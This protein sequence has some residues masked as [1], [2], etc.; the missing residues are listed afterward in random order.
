MKVNNHEVMTATDC[1]SCG[2]K[3]D[4][5]TGV[6]DQNAMPGAGDVSICA[7]CA[8]ILVFD[9]KLALNI[10]TKEDITKLSEPE[11]LALVTAAQLIKAGRIGKRKQWA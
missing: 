2:K 7:Y 1:P 6:R 8:Q 5:C 11:Q 9:D 3:L 10:A 4:D